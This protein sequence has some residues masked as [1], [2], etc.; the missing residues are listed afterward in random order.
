LNQL[1]KIRVGQR[2][3]LVTSTGTSADQLIKLLVLV[4]VLVLLL[5]LHVVHVHSLFSD[6]LAAVD[7]SASTAGNGALE[8]SR[9]RWH[10]PATAATSTIAIAMDI[11]V[12]GGSTDSRWGERR[13]GIRQ[14]RQNFG[15]RDL[16][17]R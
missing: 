7:V 5:L 10:F 12:A 2:P 13:R 15:E 6:V 8:V 14:K 11:A 4:L 17:S 3:G 16:L 1:A 9:G